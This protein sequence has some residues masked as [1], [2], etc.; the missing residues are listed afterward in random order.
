MTLQ[1]LRLQPLEAEQLEAA[2]TLD[3]LC[4][5]GLWTLQGYQRE[6]NS[7]NSELLCL[8]TQNGRGE[9]ILGVGCF[10]AILEEAHVT[11][12]AIR[13]DFQGQGLGQALLLALLKSAVQRQL[14]RATLEVRAS[15][16]TALSLYRKFGFQVAGR[17][18]GYYQASG[19]DA[20]I[21][22]LGGLQRSDVRET[23]TGW[24]P[25]VELK[26]REHHWLVISSPS[27]CPQ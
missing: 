4:L 7:P 25:A 19:E 24:E 21:L 17:R 18:K 12:L 1:E 10:W 23:L 27:N 5:G 22:W 26:L 14:E 6:L 20:L 3:R 13:P 9:A 16:N 2:V 11:L 15:N 8:T